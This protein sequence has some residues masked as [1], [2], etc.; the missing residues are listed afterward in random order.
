MK[1]LVIAIALF[2][3][4]LINA[5]SKA[6]KEV[7]AA[8]EQLRKAMVDGDRAALEKLTSDKLSYV[9]SGG[10]ADDKKEFVDKLAGGGSDFVTIDLKEQVIILSGKVAIVRHNLSA[11]TNDGGKP[12]EVN[13]RIMLTWQ[14]QGSQWILLARQATKIV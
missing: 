11:K 2:I 14:K 13:L 1:R 4:F 5:Q 10:H 6:E 12:G 7:A 3:P 8:V 9:H